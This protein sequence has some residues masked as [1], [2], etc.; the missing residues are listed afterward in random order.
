[1]ADNKLVKQPSLSD[2]APAGIDG[3]LWVKTLKEQLMSSKDGDPTDA[4]LV[5]FATVAKSTGLDPAKREIYA[6]FRNTKQKDGT[7]KPKMS[8]QTSIDGFRK[9]AEDSGKYAGSKEPQFD[10]DESFKITVTDRGTAKTV[11]NK[12]RVTVI[13]IIGDKPYETTRTANWQDYYPGD[14]QGTMWKKMPET[15]LAKVAEA[16]ALRAAFPNNTTGLYIEEEMQQADVTVEDGVD[17]NAIRDRINNAK[18]YDD[19]MD[20]LGDYNPD[21]QKQIEPWIAAKSKELQA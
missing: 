16:Q 3:R 20:V 2:L 9:V 11:P 1:M 6:I 14:Q 21:I 17:L 10:Y 4:E 13:K 19:L 18:D 8:I 5:Y 7:W 15:M 12:A